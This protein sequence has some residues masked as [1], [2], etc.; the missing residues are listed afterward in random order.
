MIFLYLK[1]GWI[2][3]SYTEE[4]YEIMKKITNKNIKQMHKINKFY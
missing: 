4:E 3:I 2:E 1:S